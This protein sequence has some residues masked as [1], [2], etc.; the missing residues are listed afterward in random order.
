MTR[1][2]PLTLEELKKTLSV[3]HAS[4]IVAD[5][6]LRVVHLNPSA[7]KLFSSLAGKDNTYPHL[8]ELLDLPEKWAAVFH[9][10]VSGGERDDQLECEEL[11]MRLHHT[12][13]S[14][15]VQARQR[16]VSIADGDRQVCLVEI[17]NPKARR[18]GVQQ[19]ELYINPSYQFEALKCGQLTYVSEPL[20]EALG[21]SSYPGAQRSVSDLMP[22][23]GSDQWSRTWS[24]LEQADQAREAEFRLSTASGAQL[25]V[26][27][28]LAPIRSK[29]DRMIGILGTVVEWGAQKR[30]PYALESAVQ[31]FDALFEACSDPILMI[32]V[33]QRIV[34][35][36][37]AFEAWTHISAKSLFTGEKGWRNFVHTEDRDRLLESI[38]AAMTLPQSSKTVECRILD[39]KRGWVWIEVSLSPLHKD[40]GE[41]NGMLLI[42]RD[43]HDR[44]ERENELETRARTLSLKQKQA[45][46]FVEKL[47]ELF[48]HVNSLPLHS[49]PF[50]KGIAERI[51]ET[52][53][54]VGVLVH[55]P[56]QSEPVLYVGAPLPSSFSSD[57]RKQGPTL[58]SQE[59][60]K[61]GLPF[62][63]LDVS[64]ER[65][66]HDPWVAGLGLKVCLGAP[67]R[68]SS[69]HL[70]GTLEVLDKDA[71]QYS[72]LDLEMITVAALLMASSIRADEEERVK[73]NL[74]AQVRQTHKMEALG[75][76]AGG[77]A[78]DFNNIISGILGFSSYL[79]SKVEQGTS[80][81]KNIELIQ[82]SSERAADLTRQLT[83]FASRKQ[84]TKKVTLCNRL[85]EDVVGILQR[86]LSKQIKVEQDLTDSLWPVLGDSTQLQQAVMNIC[87]NAADAME[88]Q[89]GNLC[90]QTENTVLSDELKQNMTG[91]TQE[92]FVCLTISD[93]GKGMSDE[94]KQRIFDPFF[95]TK[96]NGQ[97]SGLGLSI[98]YGIVNHHQGFVG[99]DTRLGQGTEVKVYLPAYR[100]DVLCEDQ[101]KS[102]VELRG[103]GTILV[104]D[105]E[106]IVRQMVSTVLR[107]HGYHVV[108]VPSGEDAVKCLKEKRDRD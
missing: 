82:H 103:D 44:K 105:D 108:S 6:S 10:P 67:I 60:V 66:A 8:G 74:E 48:T 91:L 3:L 68:E 70:F 41:I 79:L 23:L 96:S 86:S 51:F 71:K 57:L 45:H 5:E 58:M 43:I 25:P 84:I 52:Y 62:F 64:R 72:S 95:T 2:P 46:V 40:S 32:S 99:V 73:R 89:G 53:D 59:V 37:P 7:E 30:L 101:E 24:E 35:V 42:A 21:S 77:I 92:E 17:L 39:S 88:A 56:T 20:S 49:G 61:S 54:P 87:L 9:P 76:L 83:A 18:S 65:Y 98:V 100:G 28:S 94:V 106:N 11:S 34:S 33:D 27:L 97:G 14:Q 36:N 12:Q 1:D 29:S 38:K 19:E 15:L 63:C 85:I 47:K 55:L 26:F 69:G 80:L 31:R 102:P 104:V 93:T 75:Q 22:A 78:H 107:D 13:Q 90:I 4:I 81:Y 16:W 50:V